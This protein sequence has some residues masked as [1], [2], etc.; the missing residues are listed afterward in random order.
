MATSP[1]TIVRLLR[2]PCLSLLSKWLLRIQHTGSP[3]SCIHVVSTTI[4]V[5]SNLTLSDS[6]LAPG[7]SISMPDVGH[8][9][10]FATVGA[11]EPGSFYISCDPQFSPCICYRDP[12]SLFISIIY[13]NY[14]MHARW[15][16][17][18]LTA[19]ALTQ[20]SRCQSTGGSSSSGY[21]FVDPLIGTLNGGHVFAGATLPFGMAKAVSDV[22]ED[23]QGGYASN[24]SP[25][26]GFSHMH[27]SGTGGASSLA[28]FPL[29]PY[30]GCADDAVNGC[31][32]PKATR[33]VGVVN[34][35][36]SARPG[37]FTIGL[38]S[39]IRAEIT[40]ANRTALYK[41]TFFGNATGNS[42][43][44]APLSPMF[45]VDLT[46]LPNTRSSGTASVDPDTGR[47]TGSGTFNPSFGLGSY[48]A[49]FC[50]DFQG[51]AIR[52]TGVFVNNRAG[53]N[54][55]KITVAKDNNSP[56][57]PAGAFTRFA[58]SDSGNATITA[59]VGVSFISSDQACG[60]AENEIPEF[61]FDA[62]LA[63]AEEIW[64]S[65]L[66]V[67]DLDATGV[68]DSY[69]TIFWSGVYRAMLS[70]QDYTGE[71]PLW[72]SDEPYYD[73]YYCIWD[74]FR[75]IHPFITLVDPYSQTQ[76][77]RSLI[78][79]YRHEGYLP[80]CRMSLC[81]GFTQGGSNADI[82]LADAYL[83]NITQGVDWA[84]GYEAIVK[85]AEVEPPVWD[86]EGRGGLK[87][88]KELG[89]IPADDFDTDGNGVFTRSISR[90]VE[91][92]YDDFCIAQLAKAMGKYHDYEK[93]LGR[94]ENWINLYKPDQR[95]KLNG[96]DEDTGF[97]GFMQPKYL[98]GT[99]GFQDPIFCSPLQNFTSCYLNPHGH[100]TY[101]GSSWLYTFF[102]P[103]DMAKLI[104]MFGGPD[105]FIARLDYL[106]ESGLLYI[107][108][109]QAFLPVYQYHYAGRPGKSAERI[110]SYIPSQ[111]NATTAGIPGNDDSGAMGSF[112]ALS[113]MGIFPNP[114][115]D[116][117]FITPPFF[118]SVSITNRVTAKTATIRNLN[119]DAGYRN[120]YVQSATLNG[121]RYTNNYL[122]HS[123]FLEGGTLELTLGPNESTTWGRGKDDVPPSVSKNYA[124]T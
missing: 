98:N 104:T 12:L 23:N 79:I 115:Q 82:V 56:P 9:L 7:Q 93:Y 107:G 52:E 20:C 92:A 117:Y 39:G 1:E 120:I 101:E 67:I 81:K 119:F 59:R 86:V 21:E 75:S 64:K 22:T 61:D 50:A 55:K 105:S 44:D 97:L 5:C 29:F 33:S 62:T 122:T 34:G 60:N 47:I 66:S 41:F 37:Y 13:S 108:D 116:V 95:S 106:H 103:H 46:D 8:T 16:R 53:S 123:F 77:I 102:A 10:F 4:Q 6:A 35:S 30:P 31:V 58:I 121:R 100:E 99:F 70:P 83:K 124:S 87:S 49:Y 51:Y 3:Q 73:S 74:S 15:I 24:G 114:G 28:N 45:I 19:A 72:A 2:T 48:V 69:Q 42:A 118:P 85:D 76:M 84:I 80:D 91:Y 26:T 71:N 40:T 89:Y 18:G 88:W 25:V 110:H 27:D 63:Q 112:V 38:Q 57:L 90:T 94:S 32:F 14:N 78:D 43:V 96:T 54:V 109:E 11:F 65:K 36:I 17:S 111:F 68:N 113:M